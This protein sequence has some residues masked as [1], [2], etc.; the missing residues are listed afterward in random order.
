M[1]NR[2]IKYYIKEIHTTTRS[3]I[4]SFKKKKKSLD[5]YQA[6]PGEM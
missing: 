6:G 5:S 1:L 4:L 2:D 3:Q